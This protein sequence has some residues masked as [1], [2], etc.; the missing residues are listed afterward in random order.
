LDKALPDG[1]S[2]VFVA[3]DL[4]FHNSYHIGSF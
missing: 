2:Q 1:L 3:F 4:H